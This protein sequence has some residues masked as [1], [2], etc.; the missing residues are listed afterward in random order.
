MRFFTIRKMLRHPGF[1]LVEILIALAALVLLIGL[2]A[3]A[4]QALRVNA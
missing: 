2:V 3:S 4:L 1:T